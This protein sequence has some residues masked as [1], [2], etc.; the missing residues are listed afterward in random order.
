[1][2]LAGVCRYF[3]V[4]MQVEELGDDWTEF[5]LEDKCIYMFKAAPRLLRASEHTSGALRAAEHSA[6]PPQP[7]TKVL[8][9]C[10]GPPPSLGAILGASSEPR[11]LLRASEPS[12][13]PPRQNIENSAF[14]PSLL[15]A[16]EQSL[17]LLRGSITYSPRL[18]PSLGA[19]SERAEIA[20]FLDFV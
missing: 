6:E 9:I 17:Y 5:S 1:M 4:F 20:N 19:A 3:D 14:S 15:R 12:A 13:K 10:S 11:S 18:S 16:S 7:N 2:C 8:C